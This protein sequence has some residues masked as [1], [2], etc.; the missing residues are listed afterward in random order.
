MRKEKKMSKNVESVVETS[1]AIAPVD[2]GGRKVTNVNEANVILSTIS[3][4][5]G[6]SEG[7]VTV[8]L[9]TIVDALI[10]KRE[11]LTKRELPKA[12]KVLEAQ[13]EDLKKVLE[14]D[15]K[16]A[17]GA[18]RAEANKTRQKL[19]ALGMPCIVE[20]VTVNQSSDTGVIS[21]QYELRDEDTAKNRYARNLEL[22]LHITKERK[23]PVG[24]AVETA[25]KMVKGAEK[26]VFAI[27]QH[28]SRLNDQLSTSRRADLKAQMLAASMKRLMANAGMGDALVN[29][30]KEAAKHAAQILASLE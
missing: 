9:Q 5:G 10:A 16:E 21:I 17:E 2:M 22:S 4:A 25:V 6:V 12:A 3:S 1:V 7:M 11:Q 28:V 13:Q 23:L 29:I 8:G 15:K 26:E 27:R 20:D 18:A 24:K 19:V 14:K 30:E